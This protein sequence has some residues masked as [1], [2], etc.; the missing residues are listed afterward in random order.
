MNFSAI[1][2][3]MQSL[4]QKLHHGIKSLCMRLLRLRV[5]VFCGVCP[6]VFSSN[7]DVGS[8]F[9]RS[10]ITV[11]SSVLS[12]ASGSSNEYCSSSEPSVILGALRGCTPSSSWNVNGTYWSNPFQN[13]PNVNVGLRTYVYA[14]PVPAEE[15]KLR[16]I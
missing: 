15:L 5:V 13:S 11:S 6:T 8:S 1:I 4:L 2:L 14:S 9:R 7:D 16:Y 3:S 10:S 12:S